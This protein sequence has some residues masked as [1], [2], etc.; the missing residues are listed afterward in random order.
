MT[1]MARIL[2]VPVTEPEGK[3]LENNFSMEMSLG[4]SLV[5]IEVIWNSVLYPVTLNNLALWH[6]CPIG[7]DHYA[8]GRWSSG[9]PLGFWDHFLESVYCE[10][11]ARNYCRVAKCLSWVRQ[12]LCF[13]SF[14]WSVLVKEKV[15]LVF[16][17]DVRRIWY[18]LFL[19]KL[20]IELAFVFDLIQND[21]WCSKWFDK[22][23]LAQYGY[24]YFEC[25][26]VFF[27]SDI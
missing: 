8:K 18:R 19:V 20:I 25:L 11:L 22:L 14:E 21:I 26:T 15:E 10:N 1:C 4:I 6:Y 5:T 27:F 16:M 9:S 13:Q 2:G 3:S 23:H 24:G 17:F 12:L 7:Q